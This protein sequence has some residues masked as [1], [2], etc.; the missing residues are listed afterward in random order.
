MKFPAAF[1]FLNMTVHWSDLM[2]VF[3][4]SFLDGSSSLPT[5]DF[6]SV[7]L[8]TNWWP[9]SKGGSRHVSVGMYEERRQGQAVRA[10]YAVSYPFCFIC[11]PCLP[12]EIFIVKL[13][14]L[15]LFVYHLRSLFSWAPSIPLICLVFS[16][17]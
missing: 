7:R 9:I 4:F 10:L 11:H 1:S 15:L 6:K 2:W 16:N 8:M 3:M 5:W 14:I 17:T 12:F 13:H